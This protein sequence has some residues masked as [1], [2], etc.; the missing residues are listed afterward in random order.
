MGLQIFTLERVAR[1]AGLNE[2]ADGFMA[3]EA[4]RKTWRRA[5]RIAEQSG[6]VSELPLQP[7][8]DWDLLPKPLREQ[9]EAAALRQGLDPHTALDEA[10]RNWIDPNRQ[11]WRREVSD[12]IK[13]IKEKLE[14]TDEELAREAGFPETEAIK[15]AEA[16]G[17]VFLQEQVALA[18]VA[19]RNH[20]TSV[21][22]ALLGRRGA[23]EVR[24]ALAVRMLTREI[25]KGMPDAHIF[26]LRKGVF[27]PD[28]PG[29]LV[30]RFAIRDLIE[31]ARTT[32]ESLANELSLTTEHLHDPASITD[33]DALERLRLKAVAVGAPGAVRTL[34]RLCQ[35]RRGAQVADL[36]PELIAAL[37]LS[38]PRLHHDQ[39][40]ADIRASLDFSSDELKRKTLDL[41]K[42]ITEHKGS[43]AA[44]DKRAISM[45]LELYEAPDVHR[46]TKKRSDG[47][48]QE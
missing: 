33:E 6:D 48:D 36:I 17:P 12:G 3:A 22:D 14:L 15:R 4:D 43:L 41:V 30:A 18:R 25:N 26:D 16:G 27:F 7:E 46:I 21:A 1:E 42:Y 45:A 10:V 9:F 8:A 29:P 44:E 40:E 32:A 2:I 37:L 13:E 5:Y 39:F 20:L 11:V 31:K 47:A 23:F 19:M 28:P 24:L 35:S 34:T 38:D